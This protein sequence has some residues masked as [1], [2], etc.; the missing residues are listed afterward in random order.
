MRDRVTLT[1]DEV[2]QL[3]ANHVGQKKGWPDGARIQTSFRI[4]VAVNPR[5]LGVVDAS[6]AEVHVE[7]LPGMK[8]VN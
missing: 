2:T 3:I 8:E 1:L 6:V 5:T 4:E 7:R